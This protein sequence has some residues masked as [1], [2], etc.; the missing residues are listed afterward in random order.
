M[1]I[2]ITPNVSGQILAQGISGATSGLSGTITQYAGLLKQAKAYRTMAVDGMGMDPEAVDKMSLPELE[3]HFQAVA[4]K[5]QQQEAQ[6]RIA[7]QQARASMWGANT[8]EADAF[9]TMAPAAAAWQKANPGKNPTA[10][11][12]IGMMSGAKLNPRA[13]GIIMSKL[14]PSMMNGEGTTPANW[15]SAG[16]NNFVTFGHSIMPDRGPTDFSG[17]MSGAP[18]GWTPLPTNN[19]G[20][21]TWRNTERPLPTTYDTRLSNTAGTGLADQLAQLQQGANAS[22][23][24]LL[25]RPSING[26]QAKLATF[27]KNNA[28][29]IKTL[30]GQIKNH[31]DS[32]RAQGYESPDFWASEYGRYNLTPPSGARAASSGA[33]T[34]GG[35]SSGGSQSAEGRVDVWDKNGKHFTVPTSQKDQATQ[36]GYLL[37]PPT[38]KN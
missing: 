35:V 11:D 9:S 13:Q 38:A 28:A 18:E 26:D 3:G 10:T 33:G 19:K 12:I 32:Y 20:G 6:A 29:Q 2:P 8:E 37:T 36:A 4:L 16:G 15:T 17:M 7:E 25:A 27:R 23:E 24:D 34:K 5:T 1:D 30:N 14:I 31:L 22:D 21:V